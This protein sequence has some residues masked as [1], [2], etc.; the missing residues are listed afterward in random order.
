MLSV[1]YENA[2]IWE[3]ARWRFKV[4]WLHKKIMTATG[5]GTYID[6]SNRNMPD[7]T[8]S[9]RYRVDI[10]GVRKGKATWFVFTRSEGQLSTKPL[11]YL[12]SPVNPPPRWKQ[13]IHFFFIFIKKLYELGVST[14]Y[15]WEWSVLGTVE[16]T[17]PISFAIRTKNIGDVWRNGESRIEFRQILQLNVE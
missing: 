16:L 6:E 13:N 2:L 5:E 12:S 7:F 17:I 1:L 9:F 14:H 8:T 10:E 4:Y 11:V 3:P 15:V